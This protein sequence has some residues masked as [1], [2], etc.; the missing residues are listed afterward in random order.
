MSR[1]L[2]ASSSVLV[3]F[4]AL[5]LFSWSATGAASAGTIIHLDGIRNS[6]QD[7]SN[8]VIVSLGKGTYKLTISA[9]GNNAFNRF[10][11]VSGCDGNGLNCTQGF[12]TSAVVKVGS[13]YQ[14]LGAG[15]G[16][17]PIAGGG[18]FSSS[19]QAVANSAGY[20]MTLTMSQGGN[21]TL[22]LG[23]DNVSDNLGS[24]DVD[25][26]QVS[27]SSTMHYNYDSLGRLVRTIT[28]GGSA[29]GSGLNYQYDPAGNRLSVTS[30]TSRQ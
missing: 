11:N 17:G 27:A 12:E 29:D 3:R 25:V 9:S 24:I 2:V 16:Y 10:G 15:G 23:D 22:F 8:G 26:S 21:I 14:V 30:V 19:Q 5:L 7:G 20:S 28:E 18:Y 13:A 1:L 4:S 6:S